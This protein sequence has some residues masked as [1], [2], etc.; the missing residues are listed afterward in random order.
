[1]SS[2]KRLV[3]IYEDDLRHVLREEHLRNH[4]SDAML[5]GSNECHEGTFFAPK[6]RIGQVASRKRIL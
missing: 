6:G 5:K 1:M 4:D 3:S 2:D